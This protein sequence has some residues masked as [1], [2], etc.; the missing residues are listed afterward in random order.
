VYRSS[1]ALILTTFVN[2]VLGL[3]F[4]V[5]AARLYPPDVVGLGAG[6]ISALQLVATIGWVGLIF[7][8][9]RYV[10]LAGSSRARLVLT[11]YGAG[12]GLATVAALSF[13]STLSEHLGVPYVSAGLLST[14]AFC[15]SVAVWVLFTLQDGV[16]LSVRRSELVPA[17]NSLYGALKLVLLAALSGI[18]EPWTLLGVWAGAA[19]VF[20][21]LVSGFLFGRML[22]A[23]NDP[24]ATPPPA[25]IARFSVGH[26][27]VAFIAFVPDFLVP[28]LIL[29]YLDAEAN[30]YYYAAWTVG[31]SARALAV[32]IADALLVEV[33]YGQELFAQLLRTVAR[34]FA[35]LF[36]LVILGMLIGGELILRLFGPQYAD[37]GAG[38][39]R[40]FA[41]SLVPFT[42]VTLAITLDR[43]RERF[44]DA[45]LIASVGT[46]TAVGLDMVLIPRHGIVGAG[47]GWLIGQTLAALVAIRTLRHELAPGRAA[48]RGAVDPGRR[49]RHGSSNHA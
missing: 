41:I 46:V 27:G 31:L 25:A 38:L 14:V 47:L 11:V 1:Y 24:P 3:L 5:A 43:S 9:M 17:E 33:A 15:A 16:L 49:D 48:A 18:A 30:A 22:R 42:I 32:N 29:A 20:V 7:T 19:A 34:P 26:T 10:P 39:L 4:W 12:V 13:T 45:L 36:V 21:A 35:A 6:G 28:L 8:L 40:Y 23:P 44:A 37:A 2:A